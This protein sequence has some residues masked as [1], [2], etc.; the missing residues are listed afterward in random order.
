MS[1]FK[2]NAEAAKNI[3]NSLL[4]GFSWGKTSQ[5]I[6]FWSKLH[7]AFEHLSE[8]DVMEFEEYVD[9]AMGTLSYQSNLKSIINE[10]HGTTIRDNLREVFQ[11]TETQHHKFW[12]HTCL[13]FGDL[14]SFDEH[15]ESATESYK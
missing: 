10:A 1:E 4:R 11:W 6:I 5:G 13:A 8:D 2:Y 14:N 7:D 12:L 3:S 15:M 9:E